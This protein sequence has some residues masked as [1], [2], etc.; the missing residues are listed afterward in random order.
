MRK[1][2]SLQLRVMFSM[3]SPD[4]SLTIPGEVS[5]GIDDIDHQRYPVQ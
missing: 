3:F 1:V 5:D 2:L 4:S